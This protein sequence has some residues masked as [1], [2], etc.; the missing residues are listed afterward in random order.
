MFTRRGIEYIMFLTPAKAQSLDVNCLRE[1]CGSCRVC[2]MHD[3]NAVSVILQKSTNER[4][5]ASDMYKSAEDSWFKK[6]GRSLTK[7]ELPIDFPVFDEEQSIVVN[8]N[9]YLGETVTEQ[10]WYEYNDPPDISSR[11]TYS[12]IVINFNIKPEKD[13]EMALVLGNG[14][15][16]RDDPPRC[17]AFSV[18]EWEEYKN[19]YVL[20]SVDNEPSMDPTVL[21]D[22]REP[23]PFESDSAAIVLD[24]TGLGTAT[25][26]PTFWKELMR[27][28]KPGARMISRLY[29]ASRIAKNANDHGFL[30]D[31]PADMTIE[32]IKPHQD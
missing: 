30:I 24:T 12:D 27:V 25:F 13:M 26:G 15:L 32:V 6:V 5:Y 18:D 22:L 2:L 4:L 28:M 9:R 16:Q 20:V 7:V 19:D 11:Y 17:R 21:H 31:F 29:A 3:Y 10:G 23:W 14:R 8:A 1:A